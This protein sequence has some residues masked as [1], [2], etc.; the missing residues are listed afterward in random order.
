M[1]GMKG[2]ISGPVSGLTRQMLHSLMSQTPSIALLHVDEAR[3]HQV[4]FPG[5]GHEVPAKGINASYAIRLARHTGACLVPVT[6]SRDADCPTRFELR[7]L[8]VWDLANDARD[9]LTVLN[10][11]SRLFEAEILKDPSKWLN[12]YHRRPTT[13]RRTSEPTDGQP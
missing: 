1:R 10:D 11:M 4:L 5:F 9:D 3:S 8:L 7:A 2:L 12:I 6:L 13:D